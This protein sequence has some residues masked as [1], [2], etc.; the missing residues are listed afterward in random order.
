MTTVPAPAIGNTRSIHKRAV[1][2]SLRFVF[3]TF[4]ARAERNRFI[5]S[6]VSAETRMMGLPSSEVPS[7]RS[8]TSSMDSSIRSESA[9]SILV[10]ATIPC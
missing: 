8:S 1:A 10:K 5:P 9:R 3:A 6:P 4:S 7:R 2:S